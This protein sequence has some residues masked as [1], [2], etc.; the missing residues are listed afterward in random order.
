MTNMSERRPKKQ[1]RQ[2]GD[3][4]PVMPEAAFL[5]RGRLEAI[6]DFVLRRGKPVFEE[7]ARRDSQERGKDGS[8]DR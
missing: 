8:S 1:K 7:L 2:Q 4:L 6:A 3:V 5:D